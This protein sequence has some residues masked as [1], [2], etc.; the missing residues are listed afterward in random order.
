MII[1]AVIFDFDG[2][3]FDTTGA[4]VSAFN[5]A[6]LADGRR[7][8]SPAA[9]RAMIGRP[10]AEMFGREDP[11]ATVETIERRTATYR[12]L[13][14]PVCVTASR[15]MPGTVEGVRRLHRSGYRL[16]IATNR[17]ADGAIRI[18]RGHGLRRHFSAIV[19]LDE[20]RRFKP[21][22]EALLVALRRLDVRPLHAVMVGD[23]PDDMAA[24]RAAGM[25]TFGVA[26][27]A[28]SAAALRRGG[29]QEVLQSL[30]ELPE[31]LIPPGHGP[32]SPSLARGVRLRMRQRDN[33]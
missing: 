1:E 12:R 11:S 10:L 32:R 15:P 14:L 30:A 23:T 24:G 31:R 4:I 29:A 6:L 22:P 8:L 3:L 26:T 33:A 5:G 13:F 21:H 25:R 18:L 2:T 9:I 7:P 27:G 20:V 19:G 28:Y 17:R 16:A